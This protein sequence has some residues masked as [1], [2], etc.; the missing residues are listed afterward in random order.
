VTNI[1]LNI[2]AMGIK[3]EAESLTELARRCR[4]RVVLLLPLLE[5]LL[6]L[7]NLLLEM[8]ELLVIILKN[9]RFMLVV[10]RHFGRPQ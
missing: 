1:I 8:L 2:A 5:I 10:S 9:L 4:R 3:E 7:L 6:G